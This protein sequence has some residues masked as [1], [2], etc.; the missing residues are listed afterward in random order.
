[1]CCGERI[2]ARSV[3]NWTRT[4]SRSP[5]RRAGEMVAGERLVRGADGVVLSDLSLRRG[6]GLVAWAGG[7]TTHS[8]GASRNR[9]APAPKLPPDSIARAQRPGASRLPKRVASC[10]RTQPR[11]PRP[12]SEQLLNGVAYSARDLPADSPRTSGCVS[13]LHPQVSKMAQ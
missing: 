6:D 1:M 11:C 5:S 8:P 2:A 10:G 3:I 12:P 13:A 9:A 4:A 7:S